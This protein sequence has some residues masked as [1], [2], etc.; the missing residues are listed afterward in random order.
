MKTTVLANIDNGVSRPKHLL[1]QYAEKRDFTKTPEPSA[2]ELD[3]HGPLIFIVHEHAARR[4]HYDLR[5]ELDGVL[6]SWAVPNGLILE[7]GEKHLAVATED[8]PMA[9]GAFE[10]VIPPGAYGAGK[11]IVWDCGL[12]IPGSD[13]QSPFHREQAQQRAREGLEKGKLSFILC[14]TKLK[15]SFTLVRATRD[16]L[17]LR[18][19]D[20]ANPGGLDKERSP[21]SNETVGS[22]SANVRRYELD[23]LAP[24]APLENLPARIPVMMAQAADRAF[25][26]PEWIFEPKLDGYRVT[27]Y[28]TDSEV[29]LYTRNGLDYTRYFPEIVEG[30]MR[31]PIRP[32]V[33]DGEIVGFMNGRHAFDVLKK[34]ITESKR[35]DASLQ[36]VYFCFD[37]LHVAGVNTRTSSYDSRRRFLIQ[38]I[39]PDEVIQVV[40]VEQ[41][42]TM[43]YEAA[44]ETGLEGV[45]AK[46]R[47]SV[48]LPGQRSPHWLKIKPSTTAEFVVGGYVSGVGGVTSLLLGVWEDSALQF[49]GRVGSGLNSKT[50]RQLQQLLSPRETPRPAFVK[51]P[52]TPATAWVKPEVVVEVSYSE[53]TKDHKL[54]H[55]V[56]VRVREDKDA[57]AVGFPSPAMAS[58]VPTGLS[59]KEIAELANHLDGF[60]QQGHLSITGER[61]A[62]T[63]LDKVLWPP[64]KRFKALTKRDL[65]RYLVHASPY[66][67]P[68]LRNRPLTLI[69]MPDGITGESFFQKHIPHKL[70]PFMQTVTLPPSRD[71]NEKQV[72]LCNNLPSLLWLGN[73]GTI[74]FHVGHSSFQHDVK[75]LLCPDY[76]AFDLDPFVYSGKEKQ[77]DEPEYNPRAFDLCRQVAFWL[78]EVLDA[79]GLQSFVKTTGKTGLHVFVPVEKSISFEESKRV[80]E[81]VGRH[82]L[83]A[84]PEAVTMEWSIPKRT[85]KIFIDHNMNGRGRT[86]HAAYSPR[87]QA[88]ATFSMP[89]SWEELEKVDPQ[90]GR[91]AD[92]TQRMKGRADPWANMLV[93][94]QNIAKI[95]GAS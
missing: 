50:S 79:I 57:Q 42:G 80:C 86:L 18:H 26:S 60:D 81:L 30:L 48:Y 92:F 14:G 1:A 52:S 47:D 27:A 12:Y 11:V 8:H 29:R 23:A 66:L 71:K 6:K 67:L 70:P 64:Y 7:P 32:M 61:V 55:P 44:L 69:R 3:R 9:Y 15:G 83:A 28:V 38:C 34:R 17:L 43:L 49:V 63:Q 25:N 84:H 36:C 88:A 76:L 75:E 35:P 46:K 68:Q 58:D 89:V 72:L 10:G 39:T 19:H 65:L 59:R 20:G 56:F 41:D 51:R 37:L 87:A 16:W 54:R 33:L 4:L 95:L 91:I 31:Q 53:V 22:V 93:L 13:K 90:K 45:V 78:R 73:L 2:A 85:G 21:L 94:A 74:E 24:S 77:G 62:L 40:H 82:L 5:L